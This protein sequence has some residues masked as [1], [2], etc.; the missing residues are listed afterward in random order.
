MPQINPM[1]TV[2]V[3][4]G[5]LSYYRVGFV[6]EERRPNGDLVRITKT[7]AIDAITSTV[8]KELLEGKPWP[9]PPGL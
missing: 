6:S 3:P 2:L 4:R 9:L 5:Q 1:V 8:T 7:L